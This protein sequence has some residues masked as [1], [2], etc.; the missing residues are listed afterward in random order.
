MTLASPVDCTRGGAALCSDRGASG[1]RFC[2]GLGQRF[3]ADADGAEGADGWHAV[4]AVGR[5]Q[6]LQSQLPHIRPDSNAGD[7]DHPA[8]KEHF[9]HGVR[10]LLGSCGL[11]PPQLYVFAVL[12]IYPA[13]RNGATS[14]DAANLT[15]LNLKK[16]DQEFF[17]ISLIPEH[18]SLAVQLQ[19]RFIQVFKNLIPD[20]PA[21]KRHLFSC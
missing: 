8:D 2:A 17:L 13:E 20:D 7:Y 10:F 12:P 18:R 3:G 11:C 6:G 16:F 1:G 14:I 21:D 4:G 5:P 19:L 15:S 9:F